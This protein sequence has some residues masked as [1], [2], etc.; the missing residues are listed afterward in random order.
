MA[1]FNKAAEWALQF[2]EDAAASPA[3]LPAQP[4]TGREDLLQELC[5]L[6]SR[7]QLVSSVQG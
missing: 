3:Q 7:S 6:P 4:C 1:A 5:V 2:A